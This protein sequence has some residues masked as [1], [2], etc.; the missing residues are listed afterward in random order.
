MKMGYFGI[1]IVRKKLF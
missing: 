1:F